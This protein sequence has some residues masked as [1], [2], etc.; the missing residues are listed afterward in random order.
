MEMNFCRR[1]GAPVSLQR[2]GSYLCSNDHILFLN[3]APCVGIFFV[4]EKND[5]YLSVRGIEPYKGKLD[6]IG[7][8]VEK[9]ESFEQAAI[10]EILEETGLNSDQYSN[11][12]Y[13]TSEP[14][15]YHFDGEDLPVVGVFY[16][17]KIQPGVLFTPSDDVSEI[18]KSP[19]STINH[20]QIGIKSVGVALKK[21]QSQLL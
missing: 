2:N 11:L 10:R 1:C 8:F 17:T 18:T 5:V 19:L 12:Q 3:A 20:S 14:D 15:I 16:W 6:S 13:V 7:G 9:K 21:L 4:T